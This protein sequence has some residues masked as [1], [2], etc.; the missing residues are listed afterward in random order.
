MLAPS[1]LLNNLII[2]DNNGNF[3]IR[4][5]DYLLLSIIV[6]ISIVFIFNS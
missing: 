1:V 5:I 4:Y 2:V 3:I 6:I